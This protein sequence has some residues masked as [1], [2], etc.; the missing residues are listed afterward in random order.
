MSLNNENSYEVIDT[1][2]NK[3]IDVSYSKSKKNNKSTAEPKTEAKIEP[4]TEAK[5]EPKTEAKIEP[6]TEAKIEP[7]TEA[8]TKSKTEPKTEV[9]PEA[10]IEQ[11]KEPKTEAKIEQKKEPKTEVKPEAKIEQ[12]KEPKTEVKPEAKIEQKTEAKIEQKTEAKTEVKPEAKIEQ[13]TEP[14]TH[15]SNINLG[16]KY[17]RN[18]NYINNYK[19]TPYKEI[20]ISRTLMLKSKYL[21]NLIN[22][23]YNSFI[24]LL[25]KSDIINDSIIFLTFDTTNSSSTC[26][27]MIK[28]LYPDIY[29]KYGYYKVF[30]NISG[31]T[32][33]SNYTSVKTNLI[34]Y[35]KSNIPN[36]DILFCKFYQSDKKFR[37]NGDLTVDTMDTMLGLISKNSE[38]KNFSFDDYAGTFYK[39]VEKEK[40]SQGNM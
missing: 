32:D 33:T 1:D 2:D 15:K 40:Y 17:E 30:F 29:V 35:I 23:D 19:V 37:G 18:N 14:K 3:F 5:I 13:K 22:I 36:S 21:T 25:K 8:K 31:L 39:F 4:K 6:K 11:K 12:K 24:G 28:K 27:N 16:V 10:K 9:K 26:L 7:K 38:Y 34:K 20:K